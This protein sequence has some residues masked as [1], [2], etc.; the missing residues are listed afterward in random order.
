MNEFNGRNY[1]N[2]PPGCIEEDPEAPWN[3]QDLIDEA[4]LIDLIYIGL[5]SMG[6]EVEYGGMAVLCE[7]YRITVDRL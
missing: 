2:L 1:G 5:E 6:L 4:H 7:G 3:E